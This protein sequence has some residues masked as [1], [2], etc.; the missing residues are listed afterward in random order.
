MVTTH[1]DLWGGVRLKLDNATF[2]LD[3]MVNA[4]RPP[5]PK[6]QIA[7][8][9]SRGAIGSDWHRAFYAHLDAFLSAGDLIKKAQAIAEAVHGDK[10]LTRPE[11]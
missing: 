10:K 7:V 8:L 9:G 2:H 5:K 6:P 4:L 1:N 3:G 11:F